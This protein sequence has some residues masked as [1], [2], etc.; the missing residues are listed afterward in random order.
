MVRGRAGTAEIAAELRVTY[1]SVRRW[2]AAWW[3]GGV[4][5]LALA[6]LMVVEPLSPQ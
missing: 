3:A 2:R 6:S 1:R 5:A 4:A